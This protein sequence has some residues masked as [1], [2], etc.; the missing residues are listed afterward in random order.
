MKKFMAITLLIL[1]LLPMLMHTSAAVEP[2]ITMQPQNPHYPEYAVASYTVKASGTNLHCYWYLEYEGKTYNLSDNTNGIEPWEGYAGESYGGV[3]EDANTFVWFF[4]GIE[5][6][7][8]G[9]QIWCEI[10]DGHYSVTS[11]RAVITVQG[12]AMPPVIF[13]MPAAVTANRG[14]SVD[15]RCQAYAPGS[16]QLSYTWYETTSG[17]LW[18]IKAIQPEEDSDFMFVDTS[19][20]GTRYYVCGISTSDGGMTYSSV[21]PVT[22]LDYDPE[23]QPEM[24]ILTTSLPDA[25][26]GQEYKAELKCNDL[27]GLFTLYYNPGKLNQ[28]EGSGLRLIKENFI[29]GTPL[30][31]GTITFTVCAS[32]DYG[33]DYREYTITVKEAP[34]VP[35]ETQPDPTQTDP[36]GTVPQQTEAPE[37]TGDT[38]ITEKDPQ[39]TEVEGQGFNWKKLLPWVIVLLVI[40]CAVLAGVVVGVVVIVIIKKKRK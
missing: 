6:G 24:E 32:G 34:E 25:V 2:K 35:E 15:I 27:Y 28:L 19:S 1:M 8:N 13:D 3:Q 31:A 20:V 7:L 14:D 16:S 11:D 33:E 5:A 23:P 22:V 39:N 36:T 29:V 21:V 18:D 40:A 10:E 4:S 38:Q 30:K 26:V 37:V 17:R 12:S 9:A